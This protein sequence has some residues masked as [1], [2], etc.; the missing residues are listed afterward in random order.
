MHIKKKIIKY[1][2]EP[3]FLSYYEI[4]SKIQQGWTRVWYEDGQAPYAYSGDQW[5]GYSDPE[6]LKASVF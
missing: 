5:V 2:R 6:S 1:T 3:G 4:C